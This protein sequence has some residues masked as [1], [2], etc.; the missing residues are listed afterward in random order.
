M[1]LNHKKNCKCGMCKAIRGETK[2]KNNPSFKYNISKKELFDL[3][4]KKNLSTKEISNIFNCHPATIMSK[5]KKYNIK[6]RTLQEAIKNTFDKGGKS[7]TYGKRWAKNEKFYCKDCGKEIT[8]WSCYYGSKRCRSCSAKN[9]FKNPRNNPRFGKPFK[10]KWGKYKGVNMRSSWEIAY[11][12]YLD[13]NDIKW[14]YESKT[15]DLGNTTYTPDFYLPEWDCYIEIKGWMSPSALKKIKKFIRRFPKQK[16]L[17]LKKEDLER[18]Q[19]LKR[20]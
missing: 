1:K 14:L 20:R 17:I 6:R 7:H 16:F 11:A 19:I 8:Y 12:K 5:M 18:K 13:K 10:P 9:R 4:W 15:F 3:Y 2:G